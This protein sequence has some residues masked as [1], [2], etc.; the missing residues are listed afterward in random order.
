MKTVNHRVCLTLLAALL[1]ACATTEGEAPEKDQPLTVAEVLASTMDEEAYGPTRRCL[2]EHQF[3][4]TQVLD[5]Q[6]ILFWGRGDKAWLNTLTTKCIG[7][8]PRDTLELELRSGQLCRLDT[9]GS[10]DLTT[11]GP[12]RKSARCAL[13]DFR[14]MTHE[15]AKVLT[16]ELDR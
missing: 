2:P 4:R 13:G 5:D 9:V 16:Q 12:F 1:S 14:Q 11:L 15:Q 3:Y 7:L 6:H 10:I 8:R